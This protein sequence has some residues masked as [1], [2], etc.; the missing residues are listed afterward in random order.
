MQEQ[1]KYPRLVKSV[2][3]IVIGPKRITKYERA[4]IIAARALQLALGAP[5]LIDVSKLELK[6]P[7]IVAEKEFEM[8]VIPMI[9]KRELSNGEY[10][11]IP[12]KVLV[13]AEKKRREEIEKMIKDIFGE[14]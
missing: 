13:E 12:V 7:V 3:D 6:D 10:Q 9:I 14:K 5:P 8:G 4:R 11:L 1:Q 2:D